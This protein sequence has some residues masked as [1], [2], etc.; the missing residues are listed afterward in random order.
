M[1]MPYQTGSGAGIT[2]H[3]FIELFV[4]DVPL[5]LEHQPV[6]AEGRQAGGDRG[7]IRCS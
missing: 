4:L 5:L 3:G 2:P 6:R 1:G 7:V